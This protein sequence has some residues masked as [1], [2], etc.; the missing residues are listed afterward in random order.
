MSSRDARREGHPLDDREDDPRDMRTK[1]TRRRLLGGMSALTVAL[2]SPIWRRAT[3]FGQDARQPPATRF[4]GIFSANG[5]IAPAFF[6]ATGSGASDSALT[7]LPAILAPLD[8]HKQKLLVLKGVHMS[9][10]VEDELGVTSANKPGGPHMKGPG[11]MLTGGSLLAGSF[12]GAGGPAGWADRIS[13]DQAIANRIGGQ[14]Q[15]PSL[16]FGV[17]I[18]GQEPL[19]V[20]SYRG[21]NQPNLAIDDPHKMYERI[22]ANADLSDGE[23]AR[24][25]AEQKSVL[26]FLKDDIGRLQN[27][28]NAEDRARLDA[29]LGGIRNLEQR[30]DSARSSC[31]PLAMPE[32]LDPRAMANYPM[33]GRLQMDMLLLAFSCG[34]T[35][36]ATLMWA[37]ADSWQYYP[38]IGVDEEHHELSHAGDDDVAAREKLIKINVW[39]AEQVKYLLDGLAAAQELDGSPLLDH[40][41]VLWGNELGAGNSHSYKDIPWLLAGGGGGLRMGRY[42]Q[43]KDRPHNDLLVSVCNA[44]GLDDVTSFG[45]PGVCTGALPLS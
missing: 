7:T 41:L 45:I 35:R 43:F 1:L 30:L 26:D 34:M 37:N 14:T 28:V 44:L 42:L 3:A 29:H 16:E 36:V 10:T 33:V 20:I 19:R 38:W 21:A 23:R 15:F 5:T 6:P 12:T 9:S 11:A 17:R 25:G 24:L 39:H 8:A 18:E 4:I 32:R 40:T 22:F 27:R 31:A 2:T 13:V